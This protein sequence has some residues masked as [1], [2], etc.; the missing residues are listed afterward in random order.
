MNQAWQRGAFEKASSWRR[1]CYLHCPTTEQP[2][3]YSMSSKNGSKTEK[4]RGWFAVGRRGEER[5]DL[6]SEATC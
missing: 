2:G 3:K 5:N 6:V 4:S 1:S